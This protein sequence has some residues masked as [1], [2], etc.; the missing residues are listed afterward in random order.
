MN[1]TTF[2]PP[3]PAPV[4]S[5]PADAPVGTG[6]AALTSWRFRRARVQDADAVIE[7][8]ML[9]D[10]HLHPSE[11]AAAVAP[12]RRMLAE[13]QT[14][15]GS[16]SH[17]GNHML[18]AEGTDGSLVG[19]A[20]CGPAAWMF[21]DDIVKPFM[22]RKVLERVASVN[23]IAVRGDHR[24]QD[25]ATNLLARTEHD[26][27]AA[28]YAALTLRHDRHLTRFYQ[29][30]GYTSGPTLGLHLPPV[31]LITESARGWRYAVKPL[32]EQVTFTTMRGT[33]ALT[34]ILPG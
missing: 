13:D 3:P 4:I 5:P 15:N 8:V 1:T 25:I 19:V 20:H 9:I 26:L 29:A 7:L 21:D 24:G 32:T 33:R 6:P 22:R 2:T 27:R 34:G 12:L 11:T 16:L 23:H 31:G 10:L 30:A 18:V 17:G 28:G 14:S